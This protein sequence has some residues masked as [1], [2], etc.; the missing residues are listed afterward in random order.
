MV[1]ITFT[2]ETHLW[3]KNSNLIFLYQEEKHNLNQLS[4]CAE[5]FLREAL[6]E[7]SQMILL[8]SLRLSVNC[9]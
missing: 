8:T 9:N 4:K 1:E 5:N 7:M 6:L 2:W 3:F